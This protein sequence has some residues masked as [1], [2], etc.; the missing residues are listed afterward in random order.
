VIHQALQDHHQDIAGPEASVAHTGLWG[1]VAIVTGSTVT[2]A[3]E[4][5]DNGLHAFG[6]VAHIGASPSPGS[7]A[8]LH[9]DSQAQP[10]YAAIF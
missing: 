6:P 9:F 7:R 5:F 10:A 8:F 4:G 3:C 1:T 2:V